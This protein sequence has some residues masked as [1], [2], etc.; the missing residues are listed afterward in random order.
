MSVSNFYILVAVL[1]INTI[2]LETNLEIFNKASQW[3]VE[4]TQTWTFAEKT[5]F[6]QSVLCDSWSCRPFKIFVCVCI[7]LC[8]YK[9]LYHSKIIIFLK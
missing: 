1:V 5:W 9:K 8:V 4:L 2:K 3:D 6:L 7:V